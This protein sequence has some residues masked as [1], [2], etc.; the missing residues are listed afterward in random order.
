MSR[1]S[2]SEKVA[3]I[4][5]GTAGVGRA[6]AE[7]LLGRGYSVAVLARGQE[8]LDAFEAA[9]P[10]RVMGIKAD[11]AKHAEVDAAAQKVMDK[12]GRIDTWVNSAMLTSFSPFKEMEPDEFEAIVNGTFLGQVNGTRAAM[13]H[14]T[15]GNIVCIGS[16][17]AYRAVPFQSAYCAA[18][19]AINGFAQAVRSELIDQ[20]SEIVLSLVQLPAVN[21]PQFEWARNRLK[22][23]PQP[24]P[25]I[26][27]PEV[28]AKGVLKA[29]DDNSREVFVGYPVLELFF[30][31]VLMPWFID[32][33]LAKDG[34]DMQTT[35][36]TD[37]DRSG[38]VFEPTAREG[39]SHGIFDRRAN[40]SGIIID[41]DV[42]RGLVAVA[43]PAI[44]FGVGM[45][46]MGMLGSNRAPRRR[47]RMSAPYVNR[48]IGY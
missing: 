43:A 6:V 11:V 47:R 48:Q 28:A 14:M 15:R 18:K 7:M 12:W 46:A 5:G 36:R 37:P 26:Y 31:N 16:G 45:L 22:S 20:K 41:A 1:T 44:A 2:D 34:E 4:S 19:H 24:A 23:H 21:T 42:A 40:E 32:R 29:I 38:N 39:T 9:Y 10:G 30:G 17:L 25:P 13:K 35:D 3:V 8:R 27:Q 33:K